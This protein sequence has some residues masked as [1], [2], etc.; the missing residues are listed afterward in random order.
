[1]S[2]E[3]SHRNQKNARRTASSKAMRMMNIYQIQAME[4]FSTKAEYTPRCHL[5]PEHGAVTGLL[6]DTLGTLHTIRGVEL[7]TTVLGMHLLRK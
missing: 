3:K 5:S 7:P 6:S 1:M 2:H 4:K